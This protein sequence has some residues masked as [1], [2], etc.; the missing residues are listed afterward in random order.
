[1]QVCCDGIQV[2]SLK[3]RD[4]LC[5]QTVVAIGSEKGPNDRHS[6]LFVKG[7]TRSDS[8]MR[9]DSLVEAVVVEMA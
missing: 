1:M 7:G 5:I 3:A 9:W 8:C 4:I 2:A 6:A